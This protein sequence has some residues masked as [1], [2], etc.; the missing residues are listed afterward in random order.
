MN[1]VTLNE[2]D[3]LININEKVGIFINIFNMTIFKTDSRLVNAILIKRGYIFAV[4][5]KKLN[6]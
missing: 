3:I 5:E 6:F 4:N 2:F 1:M